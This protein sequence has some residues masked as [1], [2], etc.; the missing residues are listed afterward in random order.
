MAG[1][2]RPLSR[3]T[4]GSISPGKQRRKAL[5]G[6]FNWKAALVFVVTG[7][8]ITIVFR[9]EKERAELMRQTE[10]NKGYGK[11]LIG[12]PFQLVDHNGV[13]FTDEDLVGKFSLIYFGFT[14]CPDICPDELDKMAKITDSLE[15]DGF[16]IQPIFITC[17]PARDSPEVIKRYLE[18]FHPKFI[19]LTGTYDQIK[20][21]CKTFRVYFS[22]P[23]EV[24]PG[25]DYLVDHSIFY[26][27]MDKEGVFIDALGRNYTP[28]EAIKKVKMHILEW[29]PEAERLAEE[30]AARKGKSSKFL[31]IF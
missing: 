28:D 7:I 9:K 30:E 2:R 3:V 4:V 8:T 29:R 22:T 25:Q 5:I 19:G 15:K 18:D 26:Y 10:Q 17:D 16:D 14:L 23:P 24:Q 12:G 27:L 1:R 13:E 20:A 31:G 6:V 21:M 11:A